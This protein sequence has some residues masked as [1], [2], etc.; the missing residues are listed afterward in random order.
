MN[1]QIRIEQEIVEKLNHLK[2]LKFERIDDT[3]IV[4]LNDLSGYTITK[5]YGNTIIDA[6]ND[7]HSNLI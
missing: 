2:H 3:Y 7:M 5:G 4:S 6:I 1:M